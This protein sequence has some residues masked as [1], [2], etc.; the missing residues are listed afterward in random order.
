[1]V[2]SKSDQTTDA[3]PEKQT[4]FS[5]SLGAVEATSLDD[6]VKQVEKANSK[7]KV[8]DVSK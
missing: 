4:Y 8:G 1:M 2:D 6:A 7:E 5:P 3:A